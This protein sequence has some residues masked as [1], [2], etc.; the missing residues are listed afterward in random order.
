MKDLGSYLY[1]EGG[2][3]SGGLRGGAYFFY[4]W[5]S[6]NSSEMQTQL[7]PNQVL[8][9]GANMGASSTL[10][11]VFLGFDSE[12]YVLASVAHLDRLKQNKLSIHP[13]RYLR[14]VNFRNE[15]QNLN[16]K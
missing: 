7:I 12:I 15:F 9:S 2:R 10:I 4:F 14:N 6:S 1:L 3:G 8:A 13:R 16:R 5:P 11:T